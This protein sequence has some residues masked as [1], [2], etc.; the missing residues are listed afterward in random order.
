MCRE[1]NRAQQVKEVSLSH[2]KLVA[3]PAGTEAFPFMASVCMCA[4]TWAQPEPPSQEAL[5]ECVGDSNVS[6][7][8]AKRL[9]QGPG[10]CC[11]LYA[12]GSRH[13]QGFLSQDTQVSA[14]KVSSSER[15]ILTLICCSLHLNF[16]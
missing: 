2:C 14:H 12:G 9:P 1:R 5:P 8:Q 15:P 13:P 10:T 7:L 16:P 3:E 6:L 4:P 11:S